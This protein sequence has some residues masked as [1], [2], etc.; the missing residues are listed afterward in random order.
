MCGLPLGTSVS[1]AMP[2]QLSSACVRKETFVVNQ[3]TF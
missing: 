1:G 3:S 2:G